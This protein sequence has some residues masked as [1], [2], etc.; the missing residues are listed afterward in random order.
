[1][2]FLVGPARR[3]GRANPI[4]SDFFLCVGAFGECAL[5]RQG[6]LAEAAGTH[7]ATSIL[8]QHSL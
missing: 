3:A 2:N 5:S 1:M 6:C 8:I 7:D 4:R